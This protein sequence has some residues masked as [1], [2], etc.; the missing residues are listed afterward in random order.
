MTLRNLAALG[1]VLASTAATAAP[2]ERREAGPAVEHAAGHLGV[3]LSW[4]R[5]DAAADCPDAAA[6]EA[7]VAGRLGDN[8]FQRPPTQFIEATV[9]RQGDR[10]EVT[11]AMRGPE[12]RP[13]GTRS[14]ASRSGDCRSIATAAAL[15]IAILID[16]DAITRAP[17]PPRRRLRRPRPRHRRR[18]GRPGPRGGSWHGPSG[19][20]GR[21]RGLPRAWGWRR[22]STW[23]A[24]PRSACGGTFLPERRT[25]A[26]GD[27]FAFGLSYAEAF[28]C[29]VAP[30]AG[31][32][33]ELCAG[34]SAG[35]L[36]AV[37]YAPTPINP[38]QRWTF[39][40]TQLTRLVIPLPVLRPA[41][42]EVG[43]EAAEPFARRAFF[44]EGRPAGMDTVFTQ[45]VL[46]VTGSL[47][48]GLRWR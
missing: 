38:G 10:F 24:A 43:L 20:G 33:W 34:L 23:P 15:T 4:V 28:G 16:P 9:T 2:T 46:A 11:I 45:P 1:A 44:V 17:P 25:S 37:V 18:R 40:A 22:R 32:R 7:E 47:G 14:L 19:P 13:I 31:L 29:L 41:V 48:I 35:L 26:P 30:A 21:C 6:I 8:P 3:H 27:G 36:H 42:V 12:G 39:A 5:D